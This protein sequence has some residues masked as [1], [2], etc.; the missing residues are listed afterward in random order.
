MSRRPVATRAPMRSHAVV[1]TTPCVMGLS[2][3]SRAPQ[4]TEK[5]RG[6]RKRR[7]DEGEEEGEEA[8]ECNICLERMEASETVMLRC[9]HT[10]HKGCSSQSESVEMRD[11]GRWKCPRCRALI[12]F[13][14]I[15]GGK[16]GQEKTLID[17]V[18]GGAQERSV[19]YL[20]CRSAGAR[21]VV[22]GLVQVDSVGNVGKSSAIESTG[23]GS[24]CSDQ[25]PCPAT[26][27]GGEITVV[28]AGAGGG[29]VDASM[30]PGVLKR[31]LSVRGGDVSKVG[32]M[33]ILDVDVSLL[34]DDEITLWQSEGDLQRSR[35]PPS[36]SLFLSLAFSLA[37]ALSLFLAL[38]LSRSL[39][40]ALSDLPLARAPLI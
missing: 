40:R 34:R 12:S 31:Q 15:R 36:L 27:D 2:L 17:A 16:A 13:I 21:E 3:T 8:E 22:A 39:A 7:R 33:V 18:P 5:R 14:R 10:F 23:G 28:S 26:S 37:R 29:V 30:G 6:G 38:A 24:T 20:L 32:S 4:T 19:S 25:C 9:G 11:T 1:E 35:P